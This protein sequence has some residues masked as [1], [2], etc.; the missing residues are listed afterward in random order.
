M[1]HPSVSCSIGRVT[2]SPLLTL[3][4]DKHRTIRV[5]SKSCELTSDTFARE[6]RTR[7]RPG[8]GWR[9]AS[10]RGTNRNPAFLIPINSLPWIRRLC[11][12]PHCHLPSMTSQWLNSH[13]QSSAVCFD[14]LHA[15]PHDRPS[16]NSQAQTPSR[17]GFGE[18]SGINALMPARHPT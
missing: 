16:N 8:N 7:G 14:F 3:T 1:F 13:T 10:S 11:F 5:C 12:V 2:L 6:T 18:D 4:M 9:E 17:R 15:I